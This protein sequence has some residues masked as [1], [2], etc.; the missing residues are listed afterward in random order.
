MTKEL[1]ELMNWKEIEPFTLGNCGDCPHFR[2]SRCPRNEKRAE[3]IECS[4]RT[5]ARQALLYLER[6]LES[7]GQQEMF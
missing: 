6:E 7:R 1:W 4:P 3:A 5:N 2:I